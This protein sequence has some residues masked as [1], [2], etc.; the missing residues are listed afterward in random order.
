MADKFGRREAVPPNTLALPKSMFSH[1]MT[2]MDKVV[3]WAEEE[4]VGSR[5]AACTWIYTK[6]VLCDGQRPT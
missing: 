5:L 6:G 2:V 3:G 4:W 1:A